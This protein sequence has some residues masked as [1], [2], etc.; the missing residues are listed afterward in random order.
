VVGLVALIGLD[1]SLRTASAA[2]LPVLV[3]G[4]LAASVGK[5]G[6]RPPS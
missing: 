3:A 1:H 4:V 2:V 6:R 5:A